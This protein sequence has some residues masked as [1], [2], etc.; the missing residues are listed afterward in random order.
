MADILDDLR[1][2]HKQATTE[3]SH[4]YTARCVLRAIDEIE[5]LRA[6]VAATIRI[7]AAIKIASQEK[8]KR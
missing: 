2:L 3:R 1:D 7:A 6:D 5:R 4:Y 8:R